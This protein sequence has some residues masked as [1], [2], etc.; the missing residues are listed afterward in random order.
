MAPPPRTDVHQHL[1]PEGLLDALARRS[2]PPF[3]RREGGAWLLHVPA[4][5]PSPIVAHDAGA[6]STALEV[7]RLAPEHAAP[8][9]E[10]WRAV[11]R[12]LPAPLGAW[13]SLNL[14]SATPGDVD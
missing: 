5:P 13:G 2:E 7:E 14:A 6:L 1:W 11:A 10:A 9:L 12:E 8:L 4:E 3:A